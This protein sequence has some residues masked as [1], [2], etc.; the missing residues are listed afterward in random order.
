VLAGLLVAWAT[1]L[2][3]ALSVRVHQ[4]E[5]AGREIDHDVLAGEIA[6]AMI[7]SPDQVITKRAAKRAART[8]THRLATRW[9]VGLTPGVGIAYDAFDAQRTV[10]SIARLPVHSHPPGIVDV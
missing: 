8:L 7:G 6:A 9:A 2:W 10:R 3:V 1:E 4:L 5:G